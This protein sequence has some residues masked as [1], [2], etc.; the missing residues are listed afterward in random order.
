[1]KTLSGGLSASKR[2]GQKACSLHCFL[3][4]RLGT[5]NRERTC[6]L[7]TSGSPW[8]GQGAQWEC[9]AGPAGHMG[10]GSTAGAWQDVRKADGVGTIR[11]TQRKT[12]AILQTMPS[13]F[14]ASPRVVFPYS[15]NGSWPHATLNSL[16]EF[17]VL[18][19][20]VCSSSDT[21]MWAF[22]TPNQPLLRWAKPRAAK[23]SGPALDLAGPPRH[24]T[25]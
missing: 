18:V 17:S 11:H 4:G 10:G 16:H 7:G 3:R 5:C 6:D 1:M 15:H 12:T 20:P 2:R 8:E 19:L 9:P 14:S 24:V 22:P 13:R 21:P 23:P 25:C